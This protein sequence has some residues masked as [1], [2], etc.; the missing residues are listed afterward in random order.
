[1]RLLS[2]ILPMLLATLVLTSC[3]AST[4]FDGGNAAVP[5]PTDQVDPTVPTDPTGPTDPNVSGDPDGSGSPDDSDDPIVPV[6]PNIKTSSVLVSWDIPDARVNG[7]DLPM[8]DIGGYEVMYRR[9][10]Q[11]GYTAIT[12]TDQNS[13]QHL[14][15]NLVPGEYEFFIAAFD[16]DGLYSDFSESTYITIGSS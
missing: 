13:T 8:S 1:M 9:I 10:D 3:G 15:T 2:A 7:E 16:T 11:V 4:K 14:V 12:L 5:E 6:S